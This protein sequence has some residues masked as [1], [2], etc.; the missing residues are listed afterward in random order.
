MM[1]SFSAI[2]LLATLTQGSQSAKSAGCGKDPKS[3]NDGAW[4]MKK[5]QFQ[6]QFAVQDEIKRRYQVR[7]PKS[8]RLVWALWVPQ[9]SLVLFFL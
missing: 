5:L 6:D 3:Y 7:L 4:R 8:K 9:W 2:L 1:K